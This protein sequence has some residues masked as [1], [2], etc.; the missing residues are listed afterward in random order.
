MVTGV[1]FQREGFL[2]LG[3]GIWEKIDREKSRVKS[4]EFCGYGTFFGPIIFVERHCVCFQP[5]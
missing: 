1:V 4:V 5:I 2:R 3:T